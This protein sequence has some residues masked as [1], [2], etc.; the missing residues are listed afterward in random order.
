MLVAVS[1]SGGRYRMEPGISRD[2]AKQFASARSCGG[3]PASAD[4]LFSVSPDFTVYGIQPDGGLH[5]V[6]SAAI[7]SMVVAEGVRVA[8]EVDG[9]VGVIVLVSTGSTVEVI[10]RVGVMTST[11]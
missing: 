3:M 4:I 7:V 11:L 8:V 10:L 5:A 6:S 2:S 1:S 9:L